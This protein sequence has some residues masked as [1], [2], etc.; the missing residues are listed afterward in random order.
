MLKCA[1]LH[2][3]LLMCLSFLFNEKLKFNVYF[4]IFTPFI[5]LQDYPVTRLTPSSSTFFGIIHHCLQQILSTWTSLTLSY[6][7]KSF[8]FK[9]FYIIYRFLLK[10]QFHGSFKFQVNLFMRKIHGNV[11]DKLESEFPLSLRPFQ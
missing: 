5:Q 2:L 10:L 11:S 9:T 3:T 1:Y 6:H 8:P 7:N 4:Q